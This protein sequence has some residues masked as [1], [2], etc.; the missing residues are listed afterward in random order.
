MKEYSKNKG[1]SCLYCD[2]PSKCKQMCRQ[3]Y[4]VNWKK[5]INKEESLQEQIKLNE[6]F[7]NLDL[8]YKSFYAQFDKLNQTEVNKKILQ[9]LF[10]FAQQL[11]RLTALITPKLEVTLKFRP[12][13]EIQIEQQFHEKS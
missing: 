2:K 8:D 11:T 1:Q 6:E 3:H 7:L 5:T 9:N 10:F 4:Y 13:E 12:E